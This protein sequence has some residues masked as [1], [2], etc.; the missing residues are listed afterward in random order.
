[1]TEVEGDLRRGEMFA[2]PIN[3]AA[4]LK[5]LRQDMRDDWFL[6]PL[7]H[8]DLFAPAHKLDEILISLLTEGNGR[9]EGSMR[10]ICD[11]PK[12][13][14]GIRYAL[15]TDFYDR[16]I[17]QAI[18]S[19][20]LPFID[21]LLSP[22][23]L[24][25]RYN[26][27]RQKEKYL[28][29]NRIE[30]WQTFEGI[31]YTAISGNQALLATDLINY[32]ENI[33]VEI[34]RS[35]FESMIPKIDATGPE[36]LRI[37]NAIASLCE[38]LTNWGFSN[39]HG[40]PQNR[41]PSSF[42]ANVVLNTVDQR[43]M[44]LG[45]DY[46]RYVDDIRIICPDVRSA[47]RALITLIGELRS[48]G[49]NINSAKTKV[50]TSSTP[51][52][53]VNE[54]FPGTD[55]R[56]LAID[57]MWRSR[58]RRTISRSAKYI[59]ELLFECIEKKE[60]QTRQFRFAVNRL[61]HLIDANVFDIQSAVAGDI[62]EMIVSSVE[63]HPA[64]T[65]QYCRLLDSLP[66]SQE[67]IEKLVDFLADDNRAMH[68]WQNYRFW[69]FFARRKQ[70]SEKLL[71]TGLR[72]LRE[73]ILSSEAPAIFIY[74]CCID[75]DELLVPFVAQFEEAWPYRHQRHF[76]LATWRRPLDELKPIIP[77]LG[78]KLQKTASRAKAY[79]NADGKPLTDRDPPQLID[80][81]DE[82]NSYD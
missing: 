77:R 80:L 68:P 79:M 71:E 62:S 3:A 74:L 33:S 44:D 70:T 14:L 78:K 5:H 15:E 18:C 29:K 11:I 1:M 58:S 2:F 64:S 37:R 28:F 52:D 25:H 50:L 23:V 66:L 20:L 24:S 43:M 61:L 8:K 81:Y 41:D 49:M 22:R 57:N 34:V 40:L 47:R 31:T 60:T 53:S 12:K 65:D 56:S 63:E 35:S 6:D 26:K 38:L 48:V 67:Q 4:V 54:F 36:K 46:Y 73:K 51:A 30:L 55:D 19:Y 59:A 16:F 7:E 39:R 76:L 10:T 27:R 32:Y 45:F 21:P 17:Y 82:L 72:R 9:Y 13:G 42:I 69:L 75:R